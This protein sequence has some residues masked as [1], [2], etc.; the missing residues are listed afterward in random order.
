MMCYQL[1]PGSVSLCFG[2]NWMWP[3]QCVVNYMPAATG[4]QRDVLSVIAKGGMC[5]QFLPTVCCVLA[6]T[7]CPKTLILILSLYVLVLG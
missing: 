3:K 6:A 7:G 4:C 5:Y 1:F 2:S